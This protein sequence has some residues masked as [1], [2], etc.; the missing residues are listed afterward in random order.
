MV[1]TNFHKYYT[2]NIR[3]SPS[4]LTAYLYEVKRNLN[5][6]PIITEKIRFLLYYFKVQV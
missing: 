2:K 5:Y 4:C 6:K 3:L 1:G